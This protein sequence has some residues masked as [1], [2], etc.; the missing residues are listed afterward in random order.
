MQIAVEGSSGL[1][2][3]CVAVPGGEPVE[4]EDTPGVE[5]S[6]PIPVPHGLPMLQL[7]NVDF[8]LTANACEAGLPGGA[9]V[10]YV[11]LD[12]DAAIGGIVDPSIQ[13]FP[14]GIGLP[15]ESDGPCGLGRYTHFTVNSER[16][17]AW[18]G[19]GADVSAED[20]E[21]VETTYEMMSAIPDWTP[22][23]PDQ[24]TPGYVV[25]GFTEGG[26]PW[27]L[28]ARPGQDVTISRV[29]SGSTS[30]F[31][32]ALQNQPVTWCCSP[33]AYPGQVGG[34]VFGTVQRGASG[35]EFRADNGSAAVE[36]TILPPPSSLGS[37]F[38][39]FFIEG[40]NGLGDVVPVGLGTGDTIPPTPS[41]SPIAEPRDEVV[42]L[43]GVFEGATWSV[44][45]TGAFAD[46]SAC[47]EP[48]IDGDVFGQTCPPVMTTVASSGE[49]HLEDWYGTFLLRAGS[50]PV[51]VVEIRFVNDDDAIVPTDFQCEM[52]PTGWTDPDVRVCV[53]LLPM[54]GS[55]T[56]EYVDAAGNVVSDEGIAW[57]SGTAE[58]EVPTPVDP[59]HG[60]TYWAVYPWVGA[61][62]SPDAENMSAQLL[63]DFGI[64]A[65]PGD[66]SCDDGAAEALGTDAPQ[67]IGVYFET[68]DEANAFAAQAGLLG[69]EA[70]PFIARV[71]TY[72]LD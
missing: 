42:E 44:R 10:L 17:F 35:V 8:G 5:T 38:D 68:K 61:A 24:V 29:T 45:F 34:V 2:S 67:G 31:E 58:P 54:S 63:E 11:A 16:F 4:C 43:S 1:G 46:Q 71:T 19:L 62:G 50:V 6:S 27:R 37:G 12:Y 70:D 51:E 39:L 36:G 66:L 52:G 18:I 41:A 33:I 59:V 7:S 72:C 64:E 28:E 53:Q 20:R 55:G 13:E 3:K 15:P 69:H 49:P 25:A 14:P 22:Q 21:I 48:V 47:I 32:F 57:G 56:I 65:F 26:V 40:A 60:G 30:D 23:P 9:A